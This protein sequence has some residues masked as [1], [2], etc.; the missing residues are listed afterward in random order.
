MNQRF[1]PLEKEPWKGHVHCEEGLPRR[2][3]LQLIFVRDVR[4]WPQDQDQKACR[5]PESSKFLVTTTCVESGLFVESW[6]RRTES[7]RRGDEGVYERSS[8]FSRGGSSQDLQGRLPEG[9]CK[10]RPV[11]TSG[12]YPSV[13]VTTGYSKRWRDAVLSPPPRLVW[14]I[15]PRRSSDPGSC[16]E[17]GVT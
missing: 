9:I 16:R 13:R 12:V 17:I 5:D 2:D 3:R 8:Q 7:P 15:V 6:S 4:G 14:D 11:S 10:V 1:R